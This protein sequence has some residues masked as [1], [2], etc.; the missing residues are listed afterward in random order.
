MHRLYFPTP[1]HCQMA[2]MI[3]VDLLLV[4]F[5]NCPAISSEL[6]N[7]RFWLALAPQNGKL[8]KSALRKAIPEQCEELV[9]RISQASAKVQ[10]TFLKIWN[11]LDSHVLESGTSQ[12]LVDAWRTLLGPTLQSET[13]FADPDLRKAI[14][15]CY[16]ASTVGG[17]P[18]AHKSRMDAAIARLIAVWKDPPGFDANEGLNDPTSAIQLF[19][20]LRFCGLLKMNLKVFNTSTTLITRCRHHESLRLFSQQRLRPGAHRRLMEEN[21]YAIS[22]RFHQLIRY[23]DC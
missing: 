23:F 5:G 7:E 18:S 21:I 12:L 19:R 22:S 14:T 3:D 20:D 8:I 13:N 10:N 15:R 11:H 2:A 17:V 9:T 16:N 6:L 4:E 1:A